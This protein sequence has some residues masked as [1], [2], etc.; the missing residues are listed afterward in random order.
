MIFINKMVILVKMFW[1]AHNSK[2]FVQDLKVV[3]IPAVFRFSS[4]LQEGGTSR[5]WYFKAK[6]PVT[7]DPRG[8][9]GG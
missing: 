2:G 8:W 1:T 5:Q 4:H 3:D 9:G 6:I 7:F